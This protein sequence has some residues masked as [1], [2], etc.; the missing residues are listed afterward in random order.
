MGHIER[1]NADVYPGGCT[2]LH[3]GGGVLP[4]MGGGITPLHSFFRRILFS[5]SGSIFLIFWRFEAKNILKIFLEY[6]SLAGIRQMY[7]EHSCRYVKKTVYNR[8][9]LY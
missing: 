6:R 1:A 8:W 7:V 3:G 9:L 5:D 2:P 4:Y